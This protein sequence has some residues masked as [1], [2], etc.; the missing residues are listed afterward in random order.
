MALSMSDF[1]SGE[2]NFHCIMSNNTTKYLSL[3]DLIS[4]FSFSF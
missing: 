2:K 4:F 1:T 3:W